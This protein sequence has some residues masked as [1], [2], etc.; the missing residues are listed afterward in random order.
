MAVLRA[1]IAIKLPDELTE[2]LDQ[3]SSNLQ[4]RLNEL[5]LRWVPI[6][7]IHL[8]LKFLGDVSEASL[9]LVTEILKTQAGAQK[10][11]DVS[12]G[13]L[14]I[15]PN[16]KQPRVIWVGVEAPD[17]LEIFQRRIDSETSRLGYALDKRR[18][19]AHLTLGRVSRNANPDNIKMISQLLIKEKVGFLGVAHI[20]TVCLY[21]SDLKPGGAVYTKL[22]ST[23]FKVNN[24]AN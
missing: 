12:V 16:M 3:V 11:F 18:Y 24:S 6:E 14:G 13:G 1:F 4:T 2:K 22:F 5:P 15:Y 10:P 19:S 20:S 7:N 9:D 23:P 17:E 21:R 8:T